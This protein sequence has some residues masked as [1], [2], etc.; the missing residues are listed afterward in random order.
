MW[1]VTESYV[2]SKQQWKYVNS[3]YN[4][5]DDASRG[6]SAPESAGNKRWINGLEFLWGPNYS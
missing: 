6:L 3:K 5:A 4:A 1:P 2:T